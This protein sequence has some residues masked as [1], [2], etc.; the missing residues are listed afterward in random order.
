MLPTR[1]QAIVE[2]FDE[3]ETS[4][5]LR[6]LWLFGRS[7]R[8]EYTDPL[9]RSLF[10]QAISR[11]KRR[12]STRDP[13]PVAVS[14]VSELLA[15]IETL[16]KRLQ[17]DPLV[18]DAVKPKLAE[19]AM[20]PEPIEV[21]RQGKKY[22][23]RRTDV[24]W[25]TKPQVHAIMSILTAHL[26]VGDVIDESDIIAMMEANVAVLDTRQPAKRVWDYYKGNHVDGLMMHGN[27]ERA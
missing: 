5:E 19:L 1:W 10:S 7:E 20:K 24:S 4:D 27:I 21:S 3:I 9:C 18:P 16:L 12:K 2:E 15:T 6:A 25:S 11:L 13:K 26:G 23:L 17:G 22:V 14:Q 8:N